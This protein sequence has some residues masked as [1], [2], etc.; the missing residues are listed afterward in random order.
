MIDS[1]NRSE[2]AIIRKNLQRD[3][4]KRCALI[5]SIILSFNIEICDLPNESKSLL[6]SA[7]ICGDSK[8]ESLVENEVK[9]SS[10]TYKSYEPNSLV[11]FIS[12]CSSS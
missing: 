7:L 3:C 5:T 10:S 9:Y 2:T 8:S 4:P 6:K 12:S 11:G 1:I